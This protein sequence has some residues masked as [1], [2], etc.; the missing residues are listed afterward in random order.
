MNKSM[1]T[2]TVFGV[3]VATAVG[4]FASYKMLSTDEFAQV[5]AVTPVTEDVHTPR[6]ECNDV[7]VTRQEPVKDQH[8]IAG[9]VLGAVAG[10]LVG[11]A[12]GGG[13]KNT[14]A[15]IAGA[16]VGGVA[17]NKVQGH[18]QESDTYQTT[19]R[20]CKTVTDTSQRTVG[21]DVEYRMGEETGKVR[22]DY[23]PGSVIPVQDGK[24]QLSRAGDTA[25]AAT[26]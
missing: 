3:A 16:V 22:M 25:I 5:L 21:Y 2:G 14:G 23:D 24:L 7:V 9:S 12:I 4:G 6:E 15:K 11:D 1:L 18:M 26:R 10:G 8:K 20:R 17:G 13:G 19:E